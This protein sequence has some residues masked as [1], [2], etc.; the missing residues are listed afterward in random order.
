MTVQ[1]TADC[2]S[3]FGT[4]RASRRRSGR[5]SSCS[6]LSTTPLPIRAGTFLCRP[7]RRTTRTSW[8]DTGPPEGD[9]GESGRK[10]LP[11]SRS[12]GKE[13]PPSQIMK[14]VEEKRSTCSSCPPTKKRGS[15][16]SSRE[17]G[18]EDYQEDALLGALLQARAR[19]SSAKV[20]ARPDR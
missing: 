20:L 5:S 14:V 8:V 1:A 18:R 16:I 9:D 6:I 4:R 10:A 15:S 2:V 3:V 7:W 19:R 12:S 17:D 11:W 13:S